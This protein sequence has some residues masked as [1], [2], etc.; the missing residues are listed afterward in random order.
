MQKILKDVKGYDGGLKMN[1]FVIKGRLD[2][3]NKYTSAC[4]TNRYKG[5][6]MKKDNEKVIMF[7]IKQAKLEKVTNYPIKVK[8]DW[9]EV[10]RRRDI[11]GITFASKFILD[12]LVKMSII[13]DDSQKYVNAIEHH[14]Y[15]DKDNPRIEVSLIY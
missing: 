9:Y 15:K 1:K 7:Y 8:I 4:R 14:V 6:K 13:T 5:A 10:N 2:D 12:A 3:L 11:D